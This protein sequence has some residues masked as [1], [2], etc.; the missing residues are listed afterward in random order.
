MAAAWP[1]EV[2]DATAGTRRVWGTYEGLRV[3][4]GVHCGKVSSATKHQGKVVY[5]GEVTR[6]VT[7]IADA[8]VGGQIIMSQATLPLP[9]NLVDAPFTVFDQGMHRVKGFDQPQRLKEVYPES[10]ATRGS[11]GWA[12]KK[13]DTE[14]R[15]SPSFHAA[16]EGLVTM[17][18]CHAEG[19]A[20]LKLAVSAEAV[21]R[22]LE[23]MA[24]TLRAAM[25]ARGGYDCRG[26]ERNGENMYTFASY[27]DCALFAVEAQRALDAADW[28]EAVLAHNEAR[29]QERGTT[30]EAAPRAR[31]LRVRMGMHSGQLK[32]IRIPSEG[33][34]DYYG[35]SANRAARV[36]STA[37]G[38]QVVCVASELSTSST[39][40]RGDAA[41]CRPHG[42]LRAQGHPGPNRARA[43][44]P[45]RANRGVRLEEVRREQEGAADFSWG[46]VARVVIEAMEATEIGA[47]ATVDA[48]DAGSPKANGGSSGWKTLRGAVG[49]KR[50]G[51][52]I[53]S[54]QGSRTSPG[55]RG[56]SRPGVERRG[57]RV[58]ECENHPPDFDRC[59][60]FY[61][62]LMRTRGRQTC[63]GIPSSDNHVTRDRSGARS[64]SFARG[65][66]PGAVR[67]LRS[68]S[69]RRRERRPRRRGGWTFRVLANGC[70]ASLRNGP[71]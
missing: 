28:P 26:H 10:L 52:K 3:R 25:V 11:D 21:D 4:M 56:S 48:F 24:E 12:A 32:R 29:D 62:H 2:H 45:R 51:E 42:R 50:S 66:T 6:Q 34:A 5:E 40:T 16:P 38:G 54:S 13:L 18:Y 64:P 60:H 8:G 9:A 1:A 69:A 67:R 58:V 19:L 20:E 47:S 70:R 27:V 36:M 63:S 61:F 37:I 15:L 55:P 41:A 49:K 22:S 17:I 39:R 44:E 46:Q 33:L 53:T 59:A 23:V 65:A 68:A 57:R 14:E 7:G 30:G 31:G 35:E 43:A 71:S